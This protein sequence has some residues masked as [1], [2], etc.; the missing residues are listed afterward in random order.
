MP[1]QTIAGTF[2]RK[3]R[4]ELHV[5]HETAKASGQE[6]FEWQGQT[7]LVS[8]AKYLL[9]YVDGELKRLNEWENRYGPRF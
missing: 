9:E 2:D 4:D 3:M 6:T 5:M 1:V 7:V 8:F